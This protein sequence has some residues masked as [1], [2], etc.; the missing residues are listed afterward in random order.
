MIADKTGLYKKDVRE[1]I[2]SFSEIIIEELKKGNELGLNNLFTIKTVV[3]EAGDGFNPIL[4]IYEYRDE[5]RTVKMI[6]SANL[7]QIIREFDKGDDDEEKLIE[8]QI[9][10]LRA[11]QEKI[12]SEKGRK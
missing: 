12:K 3:K 10:A 7:K 8:R 11:K 6:P 1:M 4:K 2:D 9:A 5:H